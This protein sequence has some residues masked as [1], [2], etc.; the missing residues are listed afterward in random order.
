MGLEDDF[1]ISNIGLADS[2]FK[3]QYSNLYFKSISLHGN[4]YILDLMN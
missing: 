1:N 3:T 4:E 2:S